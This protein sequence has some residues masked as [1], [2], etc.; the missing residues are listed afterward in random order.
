MIDNLGT[1]HYSWFSDT[2]V[3]QPL[4][5]F[6]NSILSTLSYIK[7]LLLS[8]ATSKANKWRVLVGLTDQRDMT[9]N[10]SVENSYSTTA[11][12]LTVLC[13]S[14]ALIAHKFV[15]LSL[16]SRFHLKQ[17]S[18]SSYLLYCVPRQDLAKFCWEMGDEPVT[19]AVAATRLYEAMWHWITRDDSNIRDMVLEYKEWVVATCIQRAL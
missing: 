5:L 13:T 10:I 11:L 16:I 3:R 12:S 15:H 9:F 7:L 19:T 17:I 4:L 18:W 1:V 8:K 2:V 6:T 14:S